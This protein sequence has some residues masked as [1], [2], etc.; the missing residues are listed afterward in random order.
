M[1]DLIRMNTVFDE[2]QEDNTYHTDSVLWSR[3][4]Q[5][6]SVVGKGNGV[7]AET[8]DQH[9]RF[10]MEEKQVHVEHQVFTRKK[11]ALKKHLPKTEKNIPGRGSEVSLRI[12][13]AVSLCITVCG[14][15][16]SVSPARDLLDDER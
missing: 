10:S 3:I 7:A 11:S 2:C 14:G 9:R 5:P 8:F 13:R 12:K 16:S 4:S 15:S 1:S 6:F